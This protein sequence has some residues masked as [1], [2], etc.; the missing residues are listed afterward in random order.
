MRRSSAISPSAMGTLKST[1][2]STERP[3]TEGRSSRVG[4]PKIATYS[5]AF[6]VA[7]PTISTRS[8]RRFE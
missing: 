6:F 5:A 8:T 7:F 4:T 1:R 3:S 2:T